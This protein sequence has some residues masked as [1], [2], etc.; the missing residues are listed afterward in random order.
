MCNERDTSWESLQFKAAVTCTQK[1]DESQ[2]NQTNWLIYQ[3][4]YVIGFHLFIEAI[5]IT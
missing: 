3:Q 2:I 4:A 1:V 5:K